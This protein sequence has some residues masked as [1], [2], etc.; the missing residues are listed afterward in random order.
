[1]RSSID[2]SLPQK[3]ARLLLGAFMLTA[4]IGHFTIQRQEFQAQVPDWVPLSKDLV[5]ILSGAVE[6]ILGL[7]MILWKRKMV[8]VGIALASFYLLIF[9]GNIAQYLN[10]TNAFGLDTDRARLIRLF[11][12]PVLIIWALWSTGALKALRLRNKFVSAIPTNFYDL[13]AKDIRGNLV[14]LN[15]F[16][17]QTILIVNTAT[18]CGL[19]PQFEGLESLYQTYKDQN[20][21]VLGFPS[22]QFAHQEPGDDA[23]VAQ[24]CAVNFGVTFP[25]FSKIDV[26]GPDTHPVFQFLK[27]ELG[28]FLSD[29]IK[30]NFTKFLIDK[31]G[32]PIKRFAPTTKPDQIESHIRKII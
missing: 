29:D 25:L 31:N 21:V 20:F 13:E 15:A 26:N 10:Q 27:Q 17:G 5:V 4:A 23:A 16:K 14:S 24:S 8:W 6:L 3:I 7:S 22:N 9:P 12:Q 19:A 11:F 2:T 30:W 32:K 18:K 1:M 28:G